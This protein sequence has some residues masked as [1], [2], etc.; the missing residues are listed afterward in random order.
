[1]GKLE[2][3]SGRESGLVW[4]FGSSLRDGCG[5]HELRGMDVDDDE[6]GEV[7]VRYVAPDWALVLACTHGLGLCHYGLASL[8]MIPPR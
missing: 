8:A 4:W 3:G 6:L 1:M 7:G 2:G 5:V